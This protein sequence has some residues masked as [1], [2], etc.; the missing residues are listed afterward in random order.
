MPGLLPVDACIP[1]PIILTSSGTGIANWACPTLCR[2]LSVSCAASLSPTKRRSVVPV[3]R[4]VATR[5]A[6][7]PVP[8][9]PR[10]PS[11]LVCTVQTLSAT[12]M[13]LPSNSHASRMRSGA[14]LCQQDSY[15]LC[16][17]LCDSFIVLRT[18]STQKGAAGR[19]RKKYLLLRVLIKV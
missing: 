13:F 19:I 14:V 3:H 15:V 5:F 8:P 7:L 16:V 6:N 11:A 18:R 9:L 17:P 1:W 10:G 2:R 12:R 4:G